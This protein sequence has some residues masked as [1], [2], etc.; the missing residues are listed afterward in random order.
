MTRTPF[1]P[2]SAARLREKL[3]MAAHATLKPPTRGKPRRAGVA[4]IIMITP[5]PCLIMC[6]AIAFA[7]RNYVLVA[8]VI[9]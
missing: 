1:G 8:M 9:G 2:S 3:S 4:V 7:V 5:D 6:G